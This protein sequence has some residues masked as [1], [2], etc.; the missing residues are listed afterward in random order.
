MNALKPFGKT[1]L[2]T[3]QIGSQRR[4]GEPGSGGTAFLKYRFCGIGTDFLNSDLALKS[5]NMVKLFITD[6]ADPSVGLFSETHTIETPF[7]ACEEDFELREWFR[8]EQVKIYREFAMGNVT[9][10]YDFERAAIAEQE[11]A[12]Y[13]A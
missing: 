2:E 4:A 8:L 11:E 13:N 5:N 7:E 10:E 9:A 1:W 6:H 3:F 12:F